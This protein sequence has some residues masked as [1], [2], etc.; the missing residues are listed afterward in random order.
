V[1]GSRTPEEL[2]PEQ[3]LGP[4]VAYAEEHPHRFRLKLFV[5]VDDGS[6][7][8]LPVPPL[9]SGRVSDEHMKKIMGVPEPT[10]W[11][12]WFGTRNT[13][14]AI[15]QKAL[16]LVCGPEPM[17]AAITGPY[18]RNYSQGP[19]LGILGRLGVTP[20]QVWKL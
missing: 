15:S 6:K 11:Q 18:G 19:T 10:R 4:L 1:H 9:E 2:P 8:P 13:R 12:R 14:P 17:V 20:K 7:P 5:D 3:V 16:F